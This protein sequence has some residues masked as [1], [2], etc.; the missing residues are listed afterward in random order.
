MKVLV[1]GG[2]QFI[3][4][5]AVEYLQQHETLEVT[6]FNRGFSDPH[7]FP[8][9]RTI[10]GDRERTAD[11]KQVF[12]EK[13]DIVI[14][15]SG[16]FPKSVRELVG[17]LN[18]DLTKYIYVSSCS[19][20]DPK[21]LN[22][23]LND[24][25]V[26]T[27]V[28][29]KQEEYDT[30]I[31]T[32]GNRKAACEHIVK[33]SGLPYM[34]LRPALVFGPYDQTDRFY[35]WLYQLKNNEKVILPEGGLRRFS[36]TYVEDLA[37]AVVSSTLNKGISGTYNAVSFPIT[38]IKELV[39][40]ASRLMGTKSKFVSTS[41]S[42]LHHQNVSE[43][44]DIPLWL[45]SDQFSFSNYKLLENMNLVLTSFQKAISKTIAFYGNIGFHSPKAG[46]DNN[47]QQSLIQIIENER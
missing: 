16:Y 42:F 7:L 4:R 5:T 2:T 1:L 25:E 10:F 46:M 22:V 27:Y 29:T 15:C 18:Q 35:Y 12:Q 41:N 44:V 23:E 45:N 37:S 34:I 24:E 19:V 47:R 6:L 26:T 21:A 43:W 17:G 3:G 11:L 20:Y 28:C 33:S 9:L 31:A 32:Y 30:T 39:E 14:D 38:S 13:W 8:N 36:M 40:T